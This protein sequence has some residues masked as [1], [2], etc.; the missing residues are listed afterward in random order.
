VHIAG[1]SPRS[2]CRQGAGPL[3]GAMLVPSR[4]LDGTLAPAPIP[5]WELALLTSQRLHD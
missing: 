4:V 1:D 3:R 5:L 2:D